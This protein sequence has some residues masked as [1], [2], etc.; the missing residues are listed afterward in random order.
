MTFYDNLTTLAAVVIGS[1]I[2]F[3]IQWMMFKE[4]EKKELL[5]ENRALIREK[6]EVYSKVLKIDAEFELSQ[7]FHNGKVKFQQKI[8]SESLRPLLY[9][10]LF[11]LDS[12]VVE[13]IRR[14]DGLIADERFLGIPD[15]VDENNIHI[16]YDE[17]ISNVET[18]VRNSSNK[19]LTKN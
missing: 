4:Q 15:F 11:L 14:I 12:D 6:L 9:E 18:K 1:L 7:N 13:Q 19:F 3:G 5:K 8:Y 10:K 2:T 17:M 16:K